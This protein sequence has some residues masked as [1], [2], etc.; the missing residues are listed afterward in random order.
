[1]SHVLFSSHDVSQNILTFNRIKRI[2]WWDL[3]VSESSAAEKVFQPSAHIM[4][5]MENLPLL[6]LLAVLPRDSPSPWYRVT[7]RLQPQFTWELCLY[8]HLSLLH[9]EDHI[10][11]R[12]GGINIYVLIKDTLQH[13]A[14]DRWNIRTSPLTWK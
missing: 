5:E 2:Y 6:L 11:S 8:L 1:M 9:N 14:C 10:Q 4:C 13:T 7:W 12:P 3:D